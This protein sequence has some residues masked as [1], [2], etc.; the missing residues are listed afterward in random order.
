MKPI[1]IAV[2]SLLFSSL[3][4][5][6]LLA[7]SKIEV[8]DSKENISVDTSVGENESFSPGADEYLDEFDEKISAEI[9]KTSSGADNDSKKS[10][11]SLSRGLSARAGSCTSYWLNGKHRWKTVNHIPYISMQVKFWADTTAYFGGSSNAN[12][13]GKPARSAHKLNHKGDVSLS[14]GYGATF[15][16]ASIDFTAYNKS[17]I[18][19]YRKKPA[20]GSA[21]RTPDCSVVFHK[22]TKS[23]GGNINVVTRTG[24]C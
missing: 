11:E 16:L 6:P 18:H 4:A 1:Y 7:E 10:D 23:S 20:Y 8:S 3:L 24:S 19:S 22:E 12:L 21:A 13:C 14:Q 9:G 17:G 15:S 2:P 5:L